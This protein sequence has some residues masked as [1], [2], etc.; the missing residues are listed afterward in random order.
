VT[1]AQGAAL[2]VAELGSLE[3]SLEVTRHG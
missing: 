2:P 1:D 3:I